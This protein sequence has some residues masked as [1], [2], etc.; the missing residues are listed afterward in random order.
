LFNLDKIIDKEK[1]HVTTFLFFV[2]LLTLVNI[3]NILKGIHYENNSIQN[4]FLYN[5]KVLDQI[6][7]QKEIRDIRSKL[8]ERLINIEYEFLNKYCIFG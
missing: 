5:T 4:S 8:G 2:Y 6:R 7:D 3:E 1:N